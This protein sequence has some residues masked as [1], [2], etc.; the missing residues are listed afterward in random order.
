MDNLLSLVNFSIVK[1]SIVH[2][3]ADF[4]V[5]PT[6]S[7]SIAEST[8]VYMQSLFIVDSTVQLDK[9]SN[10]WIE[11]PS[12]L[13]ETSVFGKCLVPCFSSKQ[14]AKIKLG[15]STFRQKWLTATT[16]R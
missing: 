8:N 11:G 7:I 5:Q 13:S 9:I 16:R 2:M 15:K 10:I 12:S 6:G 3:G 4:I 14:I 1:H